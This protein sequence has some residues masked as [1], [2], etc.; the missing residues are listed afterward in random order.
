MVLCSHLGFP[1]PHA[2]NWS[3]ADFPCQQLWVL[4]M[5]I[6][7]PPGGTERSSRDNALGGER[8]IN[9]VQKDLLTASHRQPTN[10][11]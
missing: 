11:L 8:W 5:E 10:W 1:K 6:D 3:C 9:T 7:L 4:G 2:K